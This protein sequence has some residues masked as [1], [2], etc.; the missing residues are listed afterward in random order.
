MD[1]LKKLYF[2]DVKSSEKFY[3]YIYHEYK[4]SFLIFE[5]TIIKIDL[6]IK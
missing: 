1:F 5:K 2:S 4:L 3:N 6:K